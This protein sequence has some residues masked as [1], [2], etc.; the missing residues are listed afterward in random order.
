MMDRTAGRVWTTEGSGDTQN[1]PESSESGETVEAPGSPEAAD[2]AEPAESA[3]PNDPAESADPVETADRGEPVE[4]E[5]PAAPEKAVE[6]VESVARDEPEDLE[7]PKLVPD[8]TGSSES[9]GE[10]ESPEPPGPAT[11]VPAVSDYD[12]ENARVLVVH[13]AASTGRLIRET[14]ENF[15]EAE[16]DTSPDTVYGFELA[17]QRRYKLFVFGLALP[18]IDGPLL[19]ELI[20]KTHPYCHGGSRTAPGVIFVR[21][22]GDPR[23]PEEIGRDARVKAILTKP[24]SIERLLKSV[25][26]AL[27][28]RAPI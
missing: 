24:L 11:P 6:P 14:L 10:I 28:L 15:T 21:E 17:L 7:V 9:P 12:R 23:P 19:Y 4:P 2:S 20:C 8:A 27:E 3:E 13:P 1:S 5:E 16:V 18:H 25:E 26:G 22:D